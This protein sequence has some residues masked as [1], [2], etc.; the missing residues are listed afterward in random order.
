MTDTIDV[1]DINY[2]KA[3]N[4]MREVKYTHTKRMNPEVKAGWIA[5]LRSGKYEQG[6]SYLHRGN[7]YCCLGVLCEITP[8]V[9][10]VNPVTIE[11]DYS[12]NY[13]TTAYKYNGKFFDSTITYDLA[14]DLGLPVGDVLN[15]INHTTITEIGYNLME[16]NDG[17]ELTFN[18][19][20][21][22]IDYF[23]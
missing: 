12:R 5:A 18:Q 6:K 11:D 8:T 17:H 4:P 16:I 20:A 14:A 2:G 7:E 3:L 10:G 9:E 13:F 1:P 21:D 23:L 15:T 19:I 22:V